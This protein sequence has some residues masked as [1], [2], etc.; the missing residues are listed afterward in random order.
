MLTPDLCSLRGKKSPTQFNLLVC[1]CVCKLLVRTAE[2]PKSHAY[3]MQ[4][5]CNDYL[6]LSTCIHTHTHIHYILFFLIGAIPMCFHLSIPR[7]SSVET[8]LTD[9]KLVVF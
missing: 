1:L 5:H 8:Q 7:V 9:N 4:L 3:M 6:A 2:F